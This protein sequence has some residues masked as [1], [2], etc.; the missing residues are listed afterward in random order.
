MHHNI[1][2]APRMSQPTPKDNQKRGGTGETKVVKNAVLT[3]YVP[4]KGADTKPTTVGGKP[5]TGKLYS[6]T[7]V[8]PKFKGK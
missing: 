1:Q 7:A 8:A 4:K 3:Q 5:Y 2:K 6:K